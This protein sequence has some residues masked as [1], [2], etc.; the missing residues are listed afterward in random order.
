MKLTASYPITAQ[1]ALTE[2][3]D[4]DKASIVK[5]INDKAIYE[6][7]LQVP[8]PY[9]DKDA[10][11]FLELCRGF[12]DRFGHVGQYAIRYKGE[13]IGGIGFLY[14]YGET[15][16]IAEI[17]YWLGAT[18][19]RKGISTAAIEKI[20][21]IGF[22][23]KNL[24]RIEANVFVDNIYSMKALEKAGFEREGL[25]KARFIKH[26]ALLDAYLYAKIQEV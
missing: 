17:G 22:A 23:E 9:F 18:H 19:R 1:L 16:H 5:H 14:V 11:Q 15:S 8:Y 3:R 25:R 12:E 10:D 24:F 26:D 13:M 7:T 2:I 20:A 21:E 6:N 4:S